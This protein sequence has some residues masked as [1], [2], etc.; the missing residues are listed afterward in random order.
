[1]TP[2]DL[3]LSDP[4]CTVRSV[5]EDGILHYDVLNLELIADVVGLCKRVMIL[6]AKGH[7]F[8]LRYNSISSTR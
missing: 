8:I 4:L 1:M 6:C 3:G 2:V 5:L 7:L